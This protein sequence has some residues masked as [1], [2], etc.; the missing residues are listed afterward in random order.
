MNFGSGGDM[1]KIKI[2][3]ITVLFSTFSSFSWGKDPVKRS[4]EEKLLER[5]AAYLQKIATLLTLLSYQKK[6]SRNKNLSLQ[7]EK[8]PE[9]L[10]AVAIVEENASLIPINEKESLAKAREKVLKIFTRNEKAPYKTNSVYKS[11]VKKLKN[12]P[13]KEYNRILFGEDKDKEFP[14]MLTI[15][16]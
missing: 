13:R 10:I 12:E 5:N 14:E 1:V 11:I 7:K 16:P 2:C 15:S 3:L 8:S 6:T 4:L 9:E